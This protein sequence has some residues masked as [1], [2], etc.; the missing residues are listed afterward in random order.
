[1]TKHLSFPCHWPSDRNCQLQP[2]RRSPRGRAGSLP[3]R[4]LT[5]L[6][7]QSRI[8]TPPFLIF[9][10][11]PPPA[12]RGCC[13][14]AEEVIPPSAGTAAIRAVRPPPWSPIPLA[15]SLAGGPPTSLP[16]HP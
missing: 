4:V 15:P 13:C 6:P 8:W 14:A 12:P 5:L 11:L 7:S 16:P 1:M 10:R 2:D 3:G 9:A